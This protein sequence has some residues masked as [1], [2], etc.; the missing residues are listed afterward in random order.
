MQKG[1]HNSD[2]LSYLVIRRLHL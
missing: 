1:M 2:A